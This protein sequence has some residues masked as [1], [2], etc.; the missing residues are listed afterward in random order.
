MST[1]EDD[2]IPKIVQIPLTCVLKLE[3]S[4]VP[5]TFRILARIIG[6]LFYLCLTLRIPDLPVI[7]RRIIQV[8]REA[9]SLI[10][11]VLNCL[12]KTVSVC[13]VWS[14]RSHTN[15]MLLSNIDCSFKN[16]VVTSRPTLYRLRVRPKI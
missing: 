1:T 14:T 12:I 11:I 10:Y 7:F 3:K 16:I 8:F 6:R 15:S 9:V 4:I 13:P 2:H 5:F